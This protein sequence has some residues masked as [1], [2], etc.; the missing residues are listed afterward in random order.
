MPS[1]A[2]AE[3]GVYCPGEQINLLPRLSATNRIL[4]RITT[5][6]L[7]GCIIPWNAWSTKLSTTAVPMDSSAFN[8]NTSADAPTGIWT[9]VLM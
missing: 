2:I 5:Q 3:R 9:A 4:S 8:F 6:S 1:F 7:C